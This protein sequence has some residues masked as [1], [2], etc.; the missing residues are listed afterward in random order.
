M[1]SIGA[2]T[3]GLY[4]IVQSGSAGQ[5]LQPPGLECGILLRMKALTSSLKKGNFLSHSGDI[6]QIVRVDHSHVGRGSANY[7]IKIKSVTSGNTLEVTA[8][9]DTTFEQVQVESTLM[10]YLYTDGK[11]YTFMNDQTYEQYEVPSEAVGDLGKYLKEG[12]TMY[13]AV[14][15]EKPLAVI[16]PAKVRLVVSEAPDAVKGDTAQGAK[17]QVTLETGA[18]VM[19]PLFIKQGETIAINPETGEYVE[20]A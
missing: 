1:A 7:R 15:D 9:P 2:V 10:Q 12:Q 3:M 6:W 16:P 4:L 8:K 14:H 18:T 11:V 19:V 5:P 20:R 17:K 13:V